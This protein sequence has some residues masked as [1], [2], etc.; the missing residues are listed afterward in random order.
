MKSTRRS[1]RLF[2]CMLVASLAFAGIAFATPIVGLLTSVILANGNSTTSDIL[3]RSRVALPPAPGQEPGDDDNEWSGIILLHGPTNVQVQ[4][5]SYDV[6]GH[7]G[8][9]SHPGMLVLT[10][11]NGTIEWYDSNCNKTVY[12]TGDSFTENTGTH[13]FRNVGAGPMQ[14]M[15]TY[16]LAKGQP[17]RIDQAAP[18]CAAALGIN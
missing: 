18:P 13:Y 4:S 15:V 1:T 10:V 3:V 7:T 8:W 17:R 11:V 6:N 12:N 9:H 14:G 16:L 5:F 2:V